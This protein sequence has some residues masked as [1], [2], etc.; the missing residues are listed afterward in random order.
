MTDL[1]YYSVMVRNY[2]IFGKKYDNTVVGLG[3]A[4]I[5]YEAEIENGYTRFMA[6]YTSNNSTKE[7]GTVRSTRTHFVHWMREYPKNILLHCGGS[8]EALHMIQTSP[9]I[10][11]ININPFLSTYLS[12]K[13]NLSK[14]KVDA[15]L[16]GNIFY[17]YNDAKGPICGL[18]KARKLYISVDRIKSA[19]K[20]TNIG[21]PFPKYPLYK[22]IKTAKKCNILKILYNK[23]YGV[24]WKY[25]PDKQLYQRYTIIRK[26]NKTEIMNASAKTIIVQVLTS[27]LG[28]KCAHA[29]TIAPNGLTYQQIFHKNKQYCRTAKYK[30]VG[31]GNIF[32]IN[33]GLFENGK[34]VKENLNSPTIWIDSLNQKITFE[35]DKLWIQV[36]NQKTF[37]KIL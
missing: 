26:K 28:A 36:V 25:L 8:A 32:I 11:T 12:N 10:K 14:K 3:T 24:L 5:V 34:W 21:P 6:I 22:P 23:Q 2:T 20:T 16:H 18:D 31:S 37:F 33:N 4:N 30:L 7:I 1:Q 35:H 15:E 27:N 29:K 19:T 17:Y 13:N 9:D